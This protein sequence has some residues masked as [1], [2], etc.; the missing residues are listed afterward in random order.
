VKHLSSVR[1]FY[2]T[3]VSAFKHRNK[4]KEFILQL[5]KKEGKKLK[6]I[7][8]IFCD[9]KNLRSINRQFLQ[10]DYD[11]DIITFPFSSTG[12][13]IEAELYISFPKIKEQAKEWRCSIGEEL[14]RIIFHGVLHLC[15]YNDKKKAEIKVMREKEQEYLDLYFNS[16]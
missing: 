3:P 6:E 2:N 7:R 14:H 8:I 15:G 12:E 5:C 13:P 16:L 11:T 10:H 4:L 1:F 9:K